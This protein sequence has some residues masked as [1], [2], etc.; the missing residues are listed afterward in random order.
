[1]LRKAGINALSMIAAALVIQGCA[2]IIPPTGGPKDAKAPLLVMAKPG[3]SVLNFSG[4]KI[5][6]R[7]NEFVEVKDQSTQVTVSPLTQKNP[8]ITVKGKKVTFLFK[9]SLLQPNTTYHI[10]FGSA[11]RDINEGNPYQDLQYTFSTGNYFDSL[12]YSGTVLNATTGLPD[13]AV[14]VMLYRKLDD[15]SIVAKEK[16]LYAARTSQMGD[17]V[18]NSLPAGHYKLFAVKDGNNNYRYDMRTEWI[19]Y[20]DTAIIAT[21]KPEKATF[22]LFPEHVAAKDSAGG[23]AP[24]FMKE[25]VRKEDKFFSYQLNIDS[26]NIANRTFDLDSMPAITLNKRL[27][28]LDT[29]LIRIQNPENGQYL[30]VT[31]HQDTSGKRITVQFKM[32]ENTVYAL[33]LQEGF[34]TDTAGT[35]AAPAIYRFRTKK[36]GDY[37]M[38]TLIPKLADSAQQYILQLKN[39]KGFLFQTIWKGTPIKVNRL[40]VGNYTLNAVIDQNKNGQW[41][42]GRYFGEKK[43]PE[44]TVPYPSAIPVKANWDNEVEFKLTNERKI[45]KEPAQAPSSGEKK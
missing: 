36:E 29:Q 42:T 38:L 35:K 14:T 11:I 24:G 32:E 13:S 10:N 25:Q 20:T 34:V 22:W 1:M 5:E 7:F 39:D 4:K 23:R 31:I 15:D 30:P 19:A 9:D 2:N 41:D 45:W 3:D 12:Q 17:F 43:Q 18:F 44:I 28:K 27:E 16:P 26:S 37:G 6:F 33:K 21:A 8:V 40:R